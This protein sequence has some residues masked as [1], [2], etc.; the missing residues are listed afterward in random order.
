MDK[1][2]VERKVGPRGRI[3]ERLNPILLLHNSSANGFFTEDRP[4]AVLGPAPFPSLL[5][6]T[7]RQSANDS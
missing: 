5:L 4:L 7:I 3:A 6:S 1:K 2:N